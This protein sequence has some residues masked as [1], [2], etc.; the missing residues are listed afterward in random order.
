MLS[1]RDFLKSSAVL[2]LAAGLPSAANA[3]L[4]LDKAPS[5]VDKITY[6]C[7]ISDLGIYASGQVMRGVLDVTK[8]WD[9]SQGK[10]CVDDKVR[11]ILQF[12]KSVNILLLSIH[13]E[14]DHSNEL[15]IIVRV[16]ARDSEDIMNFIQK[17]S[18]NLD[19]NK[20]IYYVGDFYCFGRGFT[21]KELNEKYPIKQ[22][23]WTLNEP[24]VQLWG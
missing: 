7:F 1:R 20:L 16:F 19:N 23:H 11:D 18:T 5:I 6:K 10:F 22:P 12:P 15:K 14:L 24:Y 8:S 2:P 13:K 17:Y 3:H 9:Q 21:V 4:T